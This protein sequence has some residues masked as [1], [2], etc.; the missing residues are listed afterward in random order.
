MKGGDK[1]AVK[2][3][4][5]HTAGKVLTA[6][7]LEELETSVKSRTPLKGANI[8]ILYVDGGSIISVTGT[9]GGAGGDPIVLTVCSNGTP[10][11]VTVVG[12]SG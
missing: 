6:K 5:L 1:N 2:P 10:S 12:Y 3:V 4:P 9:L 7:Y 11:V 8:D